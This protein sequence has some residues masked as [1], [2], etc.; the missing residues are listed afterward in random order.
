MVPACSPPASPDRPE[1]TGFL[2]QVAAPACGEAAVVGF[3][4]DPV[5]AVR[6]LQGH[7]FLPAFAFASPV[8]LCS[9]GG[10]FW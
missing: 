8:G 7:G 3:G 1:A 9:F 2:P 5:E 6:S 10:G 4:V